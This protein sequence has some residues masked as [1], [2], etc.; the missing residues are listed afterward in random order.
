MYWEVL[1]G[2]GRAGGLCG[3][4]LV[5]LGGNWEVLG[6]TGR[7]WEVILGGAEV[8]VGWDW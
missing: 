3:V 1:G 4:G 2:T 5:I 8:F 7:H 6:D